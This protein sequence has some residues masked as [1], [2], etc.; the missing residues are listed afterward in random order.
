MKII[1]AGDGEVGFYLAKLLVVEFQDIILIDTQKDKLEHAEKNLGIATILGDST[2]YEVLRLAGIE[3]ANLL[4]AVTSVESVNIT[5]CLIGKKL[6]AKFTIARI[7]NMEYLVERNALDLKDLGIDVLISP[8][9]L[10]TREVRYIL[11]SPALKE[12]FN[13]HGKALY[14]MG[15][16]D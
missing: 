2:S 9:S 7:D 6:G 4:I 16:T 14:M 3:S 12:T 8:E 10:A 11:K 13:F 1:I 5:T 15:I